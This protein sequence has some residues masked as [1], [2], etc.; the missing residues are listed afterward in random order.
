MILTIV[1]TFSSELGVAFRLDSEE[2]RGNTVINDLSICSQ[3]LWRC[4]AFIDLFENIFFL[5]Y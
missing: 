2:G 1:S 5:L 4:S 3:M